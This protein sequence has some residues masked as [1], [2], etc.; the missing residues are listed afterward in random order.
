MRTFVFTAFA[1]GLLLVPLGRASA[2]AP[3]AHAPATIHVNLPTN[4]TLLINGEKTSSTSSDRW[5]VTPA[6]DPNKAYSCL[7]RA[8]FVRDGAVVTVERKMTLRAGRET[9]VVM[10]PLAPDDADYTSFY[11][12]SAPTPTVPRPRRVPAVVEWPTTWTGN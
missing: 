9:S 1:S 8:E 2:E 7:L 5:F 6:L 11:N 4:A 3:K 10:G 12:G